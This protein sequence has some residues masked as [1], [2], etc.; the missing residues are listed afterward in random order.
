MPHSYLDP[1]LLNAVASLVKEVTLA[2]T[3]LTGLVAALRFKRKR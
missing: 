2:I 1:D 3:A